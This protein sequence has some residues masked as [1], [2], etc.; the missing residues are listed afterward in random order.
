MFNIVPSYLSYYSTHKIHVNIS[1]L[2]LTSI[3]AHI[4]LI[5]PAFNGCYV[6]K[7]CRHI[8]SGKITD[9]IKFGL[10]ESLAINTNRNRTNFTSLREEPK[11]HSAM[12]TR[13]IF[14]V[15]VVNVMLAVGSSSHADENIIKVSKLGVDPRC[16]DKCRMETPSCTRKEDYA[17]SDEED[18]ISEICMKDATP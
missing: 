9:Q 2:S 12:N 15:C 11:S 1:L 18:K 8:I 16:S 10:S 13:F 14:G 6:S 17:D 7:A 4:H 3:I 5:S